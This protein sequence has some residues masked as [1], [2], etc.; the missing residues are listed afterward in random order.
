M[1]SNSSITRRRAISL[2]L[3]AG[4]AAAGAAL[5]FGHLRTEPVETPVADQDPLAALGNRYLSTAG[6]HF[7]PQALAG[8][9]EIPVS[10]DRAEIRRHIPQLRLRAKVDFA[11]GDVVE[12]DQWILARTEARTAAL[13]ALTRA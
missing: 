4:G 13:V 12:V 8:E 10:A 3:A 6:E 5:C 7:D 2:T 9:L 11:A 1:T